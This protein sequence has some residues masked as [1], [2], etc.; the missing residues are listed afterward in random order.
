MRC[1][2]DLYGD[3]AAGTGSIFGESA[4]KGWADRPATTV[5]CYGRNRAISRDAHATTSRCRSLLIAIGVSRACACLTD[6][7]KTCRRPILGDALRRDDKAAGDEALMASTDGG[8]VGE[9]G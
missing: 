6:A 2:T 4:A 8:F 7:G 5:A 1:A 3:L 9:D